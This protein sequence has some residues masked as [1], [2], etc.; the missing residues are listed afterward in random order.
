MVRPDFLAINPSGMDMTQVQW[1]LTIKQ[2]TEGHLSSDEW[3]ILAMQD[4]YGFYLA[5]DK[6]NEKQK[7]S[8]LVELKRRLEI[9]S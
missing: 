2:H 4:I 8:L 7:K 3:M 1:D 6:L 5:K 9:L